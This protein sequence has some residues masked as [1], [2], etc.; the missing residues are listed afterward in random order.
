MTVQSLDQHI[1]ATP[2]T[3]GGK[4]RIA[5]RRISVED[6]AIWHVRLGKTVDEICASISR[7]PRFMPR[8]P[9]T[10][11]INPRSSEPSTKVTRSCGPCVIARPPSSPNALRSGGLSSV[12]YYMDEH[13]GTAVVHGLRRRGVDVTT[14]AEADMRGRNDE[15]QLALAL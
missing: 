10:M 15:S 9:T 3:L 5:G 13:V 8:S 14:V 7:W 4:A 12:R 6:I 2:D 1:V 11:T